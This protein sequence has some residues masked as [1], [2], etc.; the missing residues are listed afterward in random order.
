MKI[1]I[2]EATLENVPMKISVKSERTLFVIASL[3]VVKELT[4]TIG[5]ALKNEEIDLGYY[6]EAATE[7]AMQFV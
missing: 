5:N 1:E 3:S 7:K 6:E 2:Q 4:R